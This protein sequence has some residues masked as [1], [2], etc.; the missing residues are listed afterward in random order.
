MATYYD[1]L[2]VS[3]DASI[4]EISKAYRELSK[5]YHPDKSDDPDAEKKFIEI[6]NAYEILK[7]PITRS[8]YDSK[9]PYNKYNDIINKIRRKKQQFNEDLEM[10]M[11]YSRISFIILIVIF[12]GLLI[13][14]F[15]YSEKTTIKKHTKKLNISTSIKK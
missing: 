7:N 12:I 14:S 10:S 11:Y 1:I 4:S 3:R 15:L 5:K 6:V 9:L 2:G 8:E 13:Y